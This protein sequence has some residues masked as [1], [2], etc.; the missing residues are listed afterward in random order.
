MVYRL[1]D[2]EDNMPIFEFR[3]KYENPALNGQLY[4]VIGYYKVFNDYVLDYE[5]MADVS[6]KWD[7]CSHWWFNGMD[8]TEENDEINGYYHICGGRGYIEFIRGMA[9]V[10][11]LAKI[12]I[13]SFSVEFSEYELIEELNLLDG[14]KIIEIEQ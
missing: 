6:I 4:S 13:G 7:N 3:A 8:Y 2:E 14:Y 12:K 9:F 10:Y 5:F 11:E 1:I